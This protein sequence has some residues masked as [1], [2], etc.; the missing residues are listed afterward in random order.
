[1]GNRTTII[2]RSQSLGVAQAYLEALEACGHTPVLL[3]TRTSSLIPHARLLSWKSLDQVHEVRASV[4]PA[5]DEGSIIDWERYRRSRT[6]WTTVSE[7]HDFPPRIIIRLGPAAGDLDLLAEVH[8]IE[9]RS[10]VEEV[11]LRGATASAPGSEGMP[12]PTTPSA[13][14][15]SAAISDRDLDHRPIARVDGRFTA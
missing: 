2:A 10:P 12:S 8:A 13:G 14:N 15:A 1:M 3:E 6:W 4:G 7:L 11:D 9:D 5:G